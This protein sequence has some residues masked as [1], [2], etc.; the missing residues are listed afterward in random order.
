MDHQK[1]FVL[2]YALVFIHHD[3]LD[4]VSHFC[5]RL[6]S[7][8]TVL[9]IVGSRCIGWKLELKR[10]DVVSWLERI[11]ELEAS[12]F[13]IKILLWC[14]GLN[15]WGSLSIVHG[16]P[17][18][19]FF[20]TIHSYFHSFSFNRGRNSDVNLAINRISWVVEWLI[21]F[22]VK[23]TTLKLWSRINLISHSNVINN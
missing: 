5:F 8:F 3:G 20:F 22:D 21:G 11:L 17:E 4:G 14:L 23:I 6:V 12:S 1:L 18:T 10:N 16:V 7:V 2:H 13:E 19:G 9:P 15:S